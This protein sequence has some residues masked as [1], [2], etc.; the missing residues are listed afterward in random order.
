MV[1]IY[2]MLIVFFLIFAYSLILNILNYSNHQSTKYLI[3]WF[4]TLLFINLFITFSIY[5][6]YYYKK[7]INPYQGRV[8][9]A[10]YEGKIG[11][12]GAN[13]IECAK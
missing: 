12:K 10:G 3:I 13:T 7:N 2:G 8:G 6:Y 11:E 4:T 5:G 1:I 9:I